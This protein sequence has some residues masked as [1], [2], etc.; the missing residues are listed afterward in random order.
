MLFAFSR[1]AGTIASRIIMMVR[2]TTAFAFFIDLRFDIVDQI[3]MPMGKEKYVIDYADLLLYPSTC[4]YL[5]FLLPILNLH[6]IR[7]NN[8]SLQAKA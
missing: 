6:L 8:L 3:M 7:D 4:D 2:M 5:A 1:M